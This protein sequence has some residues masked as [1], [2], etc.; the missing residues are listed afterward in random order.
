[1]PLTHLQLHGSVGPA[2]CLE[3]AR[4]TGCQVI[5]AFRVDSNADLQDTERYHT[6]FHLLDAKVR[7]LHGGTGEAWDWTL[8][9]QRRSDLPLILSGGLTAQNVGDGIRTVRPYAV[10][11]ASGVEASP[12]VKDPDKLI[13][14]IGAALAMLAAPSAPDRP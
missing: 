2:F 8:A 9:A 3:A 6:D 5:R 13:A 12:G 1:M 10:D 4:R 14:F 7:D 11:V